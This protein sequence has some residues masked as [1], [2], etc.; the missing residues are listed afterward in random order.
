MYGADKYDYQDRDQL[1]KT[2]FAAA[3]TDFL[4]A[5]PCHIDR[6]VDWIITNPP[7]K[8]AEG[9]ALRALEIARVGVCL[10]LRTN[11]LEGKDRYENLFSRYPPAFV[12]QF[13]ERVTMTEG[14]IADQTKQSATSYAWFCWRAKRLTCLLYTSPSPR[15]S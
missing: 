15:D 5:K 1:Q 13:V 14:R 6:D 8:L 11:W 9:F 2:N 7:F 12:A 10:L 4:S 3:P